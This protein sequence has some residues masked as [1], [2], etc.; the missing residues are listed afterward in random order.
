MNHKEAIET[1]ARVAMRQEGLHPDDLEE[2]Y[3]G[4]VDDVGVIVRAYLEARYDD[5]TEEH[6]TPADYCHACCAE[7]LLADFGET[8]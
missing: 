5:H 7:T 4:Y 1:A 2:Q 3:G 6:W 8:P